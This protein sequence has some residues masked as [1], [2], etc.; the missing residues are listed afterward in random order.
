M[1]SW[2]KKK[3]LSTAHASQRAELSD[4]YR[5]LSVLDPPELGFQLGLAAHGRVI[6]ERIHGF[7]LL[8]PSAVVMLDP[9]AGWKVVKT[10]QQFQKEDAA[11]IAAG[12]FPWAFTLRACADLELRPATRELWKK[13]SEGRSHTIRQCMNFENTTGMRLDFYDYELM[14]DGFN[15]LAPDWSLNDPLAHEQ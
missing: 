2:L 14:P 13:L 8:Y 3:V 12:F 10:I 9:L 6:L 7:N 4:W 11:F 1:F 15:P 5:K